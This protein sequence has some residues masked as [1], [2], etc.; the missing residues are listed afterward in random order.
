MTDKF[1]HPNDAPEGH[2]W[3]TR[4][5]REVSDIMVGVSTYRYH[6]W[7]TIQGQPCCFSK[8]GYHGAFEPSPLDLIDKPTKSREVIEEQDDV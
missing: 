7:A 3:Q 1:T 2:E 8:E 4:D 6:I 5:G